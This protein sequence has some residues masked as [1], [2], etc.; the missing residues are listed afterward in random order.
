MLVIDPSTGEIIDANESAIKYYGY[1][2]GDLTSMKIQEI[3]I[4]SES[5]IKMEME[6]AATDKRNY[7]IFRHKLSNGDIR[8]VEVYSG[9][10]E[11]EEREVLCSIIHDITERGRLQRELKEQKE[12]YQRILEISPD[13]II[14]TDL[15]GKI[16]F[17]N[18]QLLSLLKVK[19]KN[20]I[21]GKDSFQLIVPEQ[22]EKALK[23]TEKVLET[24]ILDPTHYT[25]RRPDGTTFESRLSVALLRGKQND[26]VGFVGIQRDIT[27]ELEYITTLEET[28]AALRKLLD[29]KELLL[30]EV[31]HRVKNNLT[32]IVSLLTLQAEHSENDKTKKTIQESISRVRSII[33]VYNTLYRKDNQYQVDTAAYIPA[34]LRDIIK[35]Y[36]SEHITFTTDIATIRLP[37]ERVVHL[38]IIINELVTNAIKYAFNGKEEGTIRIELKRKDETTARLL[39]MDNGAGL[40]ADFTIETSGGFGT[41]IILTLVKQMRGII[42]LP[43]C[44]SGTAFEVTFPVPNTD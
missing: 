3:N 7:F 38:G 1:P 17:C 21:I 6:K 12:L 42:S 8:D 25:I 4:L 29:E 44:S 23:N 41:T 2:R 16:T 19:D 13:A 22:R 18:H 43:S 30:R 34:F 15:E 27:E 37:H 24:G 26:P 14:Y 35:V 28:K 9:R 20:E 33:N 39:V 32:M 36:K 5:E 40:P 31:N 10:V 11:W